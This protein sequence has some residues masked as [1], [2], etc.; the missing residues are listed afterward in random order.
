MEGRLSSVRETGS[1]NPLGSTP[2]GQGSPGRAGQCSEG[3]PKGTGADPPCL[4]K[5]EQVVGMEMSLAEW[6]ALDG[7]Q[8]KKESL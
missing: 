2:E 8:D 6:E 1:E 3:N 7:T 4:L 5:N